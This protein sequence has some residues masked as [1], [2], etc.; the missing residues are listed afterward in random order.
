MGEMSGEG[1]IEGWRQSMAHINAVIESTLPTTSM[2]PGIF[3][4]GYGMGMESG[5]AGGQ[6]LKKID[7]NQEINIYSQT[8]DLIE[9]SRKFK[10]MQEEAAREW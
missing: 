6:M 9:T 10:Q 1:Y 8:D 3:R 2:G 7:V 4:S 5:D